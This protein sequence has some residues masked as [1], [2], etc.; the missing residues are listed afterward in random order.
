MIQ[1][2]KKRSLGELQRNVAVADVIAGESHLCGKAW[3]FHPAFWS[4]FWQW[5]SGEYNR[6]E[7]ELQRDPEQGATGEGGGGAGRGGQE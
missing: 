5:Q 1:E 7:E 3:S 4:E 6:V 2:H